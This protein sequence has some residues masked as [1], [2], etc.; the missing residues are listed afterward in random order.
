MHG[1]IVAGIFM[2]YGGTVPGN[3]RACEHSWRE[4]LDFLAMATRHP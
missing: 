1:L 3:A 2:V 4:V